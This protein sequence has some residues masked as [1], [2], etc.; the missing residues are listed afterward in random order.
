MELLKLH[1]LGS[2]LFFALGRP[3]PWLPAYLAFV[4]ATALVRLLRAF[5]GPLY[6]HLLIHAA[7]LSAS[8]LAVLALERGTA[9]QEGIAGLPGLLVAL[10]WSGACWIRGAWLGG[11]N[12]DHAFCTARFDEGIWA[13]LVSFSFAALVRV[14]V[15]SFPGLIIPFFLVG[16]PALGI[17]K[18]DPALRG[19]FSRRSRGSALAPFTIAFILAATGVLVAVPALEAPAA[20]AANSLGFASQEFLRLLGLFLTSLYRFKPASGPAATGVTRVIAPADGDSSQGAPFAGILLWALLAVAA[21]FSLAFL[22]FAI[23]RLLRLLG[24]R[25]EKKGRSP[26]LARLLSR[27]AAW[28]RSLIGPFLRFFARL[29][30]LIPHRR[31]KRSLAL[32]TYARLLVCGRAAGAAR[33][34]VETPREYARRL[35]LAFPHAAGRSDSVATALERE[36]YGGKVRDEATEAG[37]AGIRRGLH[38]LSFI[39]ERA[40]NAIRRKCD[41]AT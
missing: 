19:G 12:P 32:S 34:P 27:L 5:G 6:I 22:L 23:G 18:A 3:P 39:A 11:R 10:A 41:P 40:R 15:P 33:R 29:E 30:A 16:I 2:F 38:I 14:E 20:Q 36:V 21:I 31:E 4:V 35:S 7:G 28:L 37:L 25:V 8:A 13:Y 1:V 26:E 9:A 17:S 24:T